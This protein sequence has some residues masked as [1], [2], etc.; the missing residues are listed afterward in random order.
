MANAQVSRAA[1]LAAPLGRRVK[2]LITGVGREAPAGGADQAAVTRTLERAYEELL[3]RPPDPGGLAFYTAVAAEAGIGEAVLQLAR[4]QEHVHHVVDTHNPLPDIRPGRPDRYTMLRAD[5]D[6]LVEVFHAAGDDDFDWLLQRILDHGY[7]ERPASWSLDMD[8]DKRMMAAIIA[9][10]GGER[11]LEIGCSSG[12]ILQLLQERG[13]AVT[14]VEISR[15]AR[16]RA[17]EPVRDAIRIG[18]FLDEDL[19]AGG[20]DVVYGLDVFEHVRPADVPRYFDRVARIL[21]PGG[22]LLANIPAYGDDPVFGAAYPMWFAEWREDF[23]AC[24]PFRH[25]EVDRSGFPALGHLVWAGWDWWEREVGRH[26]FRRDPARERAIHD[27][28]GDDL[29]LRPGRRSLFVFE[30]TG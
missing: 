28:F 14:G 22:L 25:L 16:D 20:F 21:R 4:S 27:R 5:D 2:S 19:I 30:K 9:G 7:Y 13:R 8:D 3:G 10:L 26:G 18:D 1:R 29:A 15:Q 17:S 23:A 11:V 12:L 24:R 6:V